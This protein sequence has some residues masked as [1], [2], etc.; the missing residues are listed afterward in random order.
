MIG[1]I[2]SFISGGTFGVVLMALFIGGS[3]RHMK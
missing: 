3:D 2:I 1:N